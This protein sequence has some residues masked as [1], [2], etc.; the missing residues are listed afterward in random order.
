MSKGWIGVDFDGTLAHYDHWQ[1]GFTFGKPVKAMVEKVKQ[2]LEAGYD[3]KIMTA[4]VSE[5]TA[6]INLEV[7]RAIEKWLVEE[8]GLPVLEITCIKDYKMIELWDDR[9]VRVIANTGEFDGQG[10][11]LVP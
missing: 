11:R 4:R 1:G 7:R 2:A 5:P 8:A 9:S 6:N 10:S 3:V